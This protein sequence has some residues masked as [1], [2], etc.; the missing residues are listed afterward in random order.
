MLFPQKRTQLHKLLGI[1]LACSVLGQFGLYGSVLD[2]TKPIHDDLTGCCMKNIDCIYMINLDERPEKYQKSIQE[3]SPYGITPYRFSAVNGWKDLSI[4]AVNDLGVRFLPGMKGGALSTR[5][6]NGIKG[7]LEPVYEIMNKFG[8][9]YFSGKSSLGVLGCILSHLSILKH[10]FDQRYNT[11]WVMEDDICILK[12]PHILS[13]KIDELDRLIGDN[14]WDILFTDY[15]FRN[16]KGEYVPSRGYKPR[17]N[18]KPKSLASL[19]INHQVGNSFRRVGGRF[20]THSMII[21]RSGIKKLLNFFQKYKLFHP[22]DMELNAPNNMR[23][24][25]VLEDVVSN[26]LERLSDI[27]NPRY[28]LSPSS[29]YAE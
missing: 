11:I 20:G 19:Q 6:I 12:N 29:N 16:S 1:I 26:Q 21:R 2:Y 9:V 27:T 13:K 17:P 24:F 4:D 7:E 3:L 15:D 8:K 22:M 18:Y 25:T 5:F 10:A 14:G 23:L 28:K